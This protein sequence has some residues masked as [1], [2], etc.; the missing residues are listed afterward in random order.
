MGS[1]QD[2][3]PIIRRLDDH[4]APW[5]MDLPGHG[6]AAGLTDEF[7]CFERAAERLTDWL[8]EFR[9]P[10]CVP[11]GYSMGG[12]MALYFAVKHPEHCK[13]LILESTSP[14]I[15]DEDERLDRLSHDFDLA[16]QLEDGNLEEFI[17]NWYHQPMF[18]RLSED[19]GKLENIFRKRQ[20]NDPWE[21]ARALRGFSPGIQPPLW[22]HLAK[23]NF[24]VLV[25]AGAL[26]KKYVQI[27]EE[28]VERLPLGQLSVVD[29]ADHNVHEE[30]P[31]AFIKVVNE[32]LRSI[33]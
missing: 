11:V 32:F 25:I 17:R 20:K 19:A 1:A 5:A 4:F 16:V 3:E 27:S 9:K 30:Q 18:H 22:D 24:P 29:D 21:L 13:G 12:R 33:A 7:Y 15:Q 31:E 8:N 14:G 28:M 2:W 6:K 23:L 26:D 10:H